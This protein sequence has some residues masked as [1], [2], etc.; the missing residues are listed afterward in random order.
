MNTAT[1]TLETYLLE[2]WTASGML[3]G[4]KTQMTLGGT[5]YTAWDADAE[6][7]VM[8]F[9][10]DRPHTKAEFD[11]LSIDLAVL[12]NAEWVDMR[13]EELSNGND[14]TEARDMA[15]SYAPY[16][17]DIYV[18]ESAIDQETR[19][20]DLLGVYGPELFL[21]VVPDALLKGIA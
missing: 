8:R 11:S 2:L 12:L 9:I 16:F 18:L 5:L 17:M 4:E 15:D 19:R 1:P 6:R 13:D 10:L 21:H 20:A 14:E 3:F 7:C